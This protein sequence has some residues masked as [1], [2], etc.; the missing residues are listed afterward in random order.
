M[1]WIT[2]P[3]AWIALAT[4]TALEIVLGIDNI[5]F[6]SILADRLPPEQRPRARTI[7]LGMAMGMRILLLLSLTWIIGLTGPL[8]E[9]MGNEFSGRDLILLV[10]GLFLLI[11]GQAGEKDPTGEAAFADVKVKWL[12]QI[13]RDPPGGHTTYWPRHNHPNHQDPRGRAPATACG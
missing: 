8:F 4:L 2:D 11:A 5:I 1:E 3:Q 12:L 9:V 7:G 6:I 10:G 13:A